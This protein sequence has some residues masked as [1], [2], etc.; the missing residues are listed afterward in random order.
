LLIFPFFSPRISGHVISE[1]HHLNQ[2][3]CV[4]HALKKIRIKQFNLI[5]QKF[6]NQIVE[7]SINNIVIDE[8]GYEDDYEHNNDF[9]DSDNEKSN[10]NEKEDGNN[11]DDENDDV[12]NYDDDDDDGDNNKILDGIYNYICLCNSF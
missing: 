2:L 9:S 7:G 11:S 1:V 6:L 5:N 10:D 4:V 12:D 3:N 8:D